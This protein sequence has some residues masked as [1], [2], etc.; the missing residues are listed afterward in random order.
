MK[1]RA[2]ECELLRA[3]RQVDIEHDKANSR[4]WQFGECTL[5]KPIS[6]R[7]GK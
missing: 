4:Y 6:K 3:A 7:C 2:L 5:K 1:I